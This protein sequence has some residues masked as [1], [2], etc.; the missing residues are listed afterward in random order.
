MM[1]HGLACWLVGRRIPILAAGFA[2]PEPI[3]SAEYRSMYSTQLR[4]NELVTSLTFDQAYL[5]LPV[6]QNERTAK[7]F[8]RVAPANIVL[9]YKNSSSFSAKIRRRL[10]TTAHTEWPD[11]DTFAQGL[12]MTRS[13]LRPVWT[14]RGNL[15]NRLKTNCA[16]IWRSST[17]VILQK[18]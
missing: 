1:Q 7:E 2:Y 14:K 17:L 12:H 16:V 9:K 18:A 4:F 6:I 11:F 10:R 3:Y 15:S 13:T 5:E 8:L